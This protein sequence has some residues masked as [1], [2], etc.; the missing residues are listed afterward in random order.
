MTSATVLV[1]AIWLVAVSRR[2]RGLLAEIEA[3][4]ENTLHAREQRPGPA[5]SAAATPAAGA[6]GPLGEV[7][8]A[9]D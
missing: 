2:R 7:T 8:G 3:D 4:L 1:G 5:E 6:I 9:A